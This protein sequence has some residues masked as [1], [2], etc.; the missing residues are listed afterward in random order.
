MV[1]ICLSFVIQNSYTHS[2][3][4]PAGRPK[5]E[6]ARVRG[7]G[8]RRPGRR[9]DLRRHRGGPV[10]RAHHPADGGNPEHDEEGRGLHAGRSRRQGDAE[11]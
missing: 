7:D 3:R 9:H 6:G 4:V 11:E 10:H 1:L 8:G 2:L 5:A